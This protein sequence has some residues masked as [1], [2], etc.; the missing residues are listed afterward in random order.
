MLTTLRNSSKNS[1]LKIIFGSLLTI[2]IISFGMWGTEDLVG[3]GKKQ[4]TVA[5]V[6]KLDISAKE[7]KA[8]VSKR[9]TPG[10]TGFTSDVYLKCYGDRC[11]KPMDGA[12][13][14]LSTAGFGATD[15]KASAS[16][17]Y[18]YSFI[19]PHTALRVGSVRGCKGLRNRGRSF[20]F[21]TS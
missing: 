3:V 12:T 17:T 5:S 4:S 2:L 19:D 13:P 1:I 6:G 9:V 21:S 7:F 10:M 16:S 11:A 8:Y 15:F 20:Y 18:K 14:A